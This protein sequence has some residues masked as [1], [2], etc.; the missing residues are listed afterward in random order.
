L[1]KRVIVL[2][3]GKKIA[4]GNPE[5]IAQNEQVLKAYLG[6]RWSRSNA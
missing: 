5:E 3:Y 2:H 4:D 6:R 1:V